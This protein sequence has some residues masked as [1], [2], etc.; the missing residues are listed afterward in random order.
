VKTFSEKQNEI[1]RKRTTFTFELKLIEHSTWNKNK[2]KGLLLSI[3]LN[4]YDV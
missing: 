2:R 4:K 1:L 3:A